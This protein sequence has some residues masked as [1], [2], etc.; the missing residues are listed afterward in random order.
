LSDKNHWARPKSL[1]LAVALAILTGF[2]WANA[3]V[4][5]ESKGEN[6]SAKPPAQLFNSD[7][8]GSGCHKGPQGLAKNYSTG[9]LASFLREHYTNSRES[10]AALAAYL[11][12]QPTGPEP[13]EKEAR[14]PRG[15]KPTAAA[16]SLSGPAGWFQSSPS[17]P[18]A[19]KP[20]EKEKDKE[21]PAAR[22][23]PRTSTAAHHEE[24]P[25]TQRHDI[26]H[27]NEARKPSARERAQRGRHPAAPA[28]AA[29][30]PAETPAPAAPSASEAETPK[31]AAP[32]VA[33]AP[34]PMPPSAPSSPPAAAPAPAPTAAAKAAPAA[35]TKKQ[36]DIFD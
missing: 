32:A 33:A 10:A 31:P 24:P 22:P 30:P 18:A 19:A 6:F 34:Q 36:Y 29:V 27:G 11:T 25:S 3:A 21:K 16:P 20:K 17:E 2:G 9:G 7:C 26:E 15:T 5:Q 1:F 4:A 35:G 13:K 28:T 14:T 8:T 23:E 12:K